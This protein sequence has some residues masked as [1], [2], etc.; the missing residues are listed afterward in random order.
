MRLEEAEEIDYMMPTDPVNFAPAGDLPAERLA[1]QDQTPKG[2]CWWGQALSGTTVRPCTYSC[3]VGNLMMNRMPFWA[4]DADNWQSFER[5]VADQVSKLDANATVQHDARLVGVHSKI[6]RQIDVLASVP[7]I[8][9][10]LRIAF[11]CKLY[12]RAVSIG[13]VEEFI[14]K[15]LDLRVDRGVLCVFGGVTPAAF[16]RLLAV[17]HPS[18]DLYMWHR[19]EPTAEDWL[20]MMDGLED[21]TDKERDE[22]WARQAQAERARGWLNH[23]I[24]N[25]F[26]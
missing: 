10:T 12:K 8:G 21:L 14:G 11:E 4:S 13:T 17:L 19:E 25:S 20:Y 24:P 15:L 5:L 16:R 22:I 1:R 18:I 2:V 9:G 6:E 3:H 23:S 26:L 7:A